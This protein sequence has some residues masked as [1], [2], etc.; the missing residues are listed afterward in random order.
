LGEPTRGYEPMT[1]QRPEDDREEGCGDHTERD[2]QSSPRATGLR[3]HHRRPLRLRSTTFASRGQPYVATSAGAR[4]GRGGARTRSAFADCSPSGRHTS[5]TLM[6]DAARPGRGSR[7]RR[8]RCGDRSRRGSFRSVTLRGR[9]SATPVA[10]RARRRR[11]AGR[12]RSSR[13]LRLLRLL[14][15]RG[16]LGHV[17]GRQE[18][19]R[20]DV[21]VRVGRG[22][23]A[24]MHV[25]LG[26]FRVAAGADRA[27]H[28]ALAHLRS[29]RDPDR[30]E[31]DE[32]DRPAVLGTDRQAET[33][34]GQPP[35]ER[36]DPRCGGA[37]GRARGSADVDPAMLAAGIRIALGGKRP[38]HG[39]VDGPRPG[40]RSRSER[41][42]G[43]HH[44]QN[45]VA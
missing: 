36:D 45:R 41:E 16:L 21:A 42:C 12:H 24:E 1:T 44:D 35:G 8:G 31:M 6:P 43:E 19:Q 25:G 37:H 28:V 10:C 27:D 15:R 33:L 38:Q 13:R 20:I 7:V 17:S 4:T 40:R 18:R 2:E 11:P 32:R 39:P 22:A 34:G 30:A 26:P 14:D 9:R 23:D 5:G 29:D 3:P